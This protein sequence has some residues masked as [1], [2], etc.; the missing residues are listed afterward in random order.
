MN[1][2]DE[3]SVTEMERILDESS[4]AVMDALIRYC[5]AKEVEIEKE[6]NTTKA[7]VNND[8]EISIMKREVNVKKAEDL[9]KMKSKAL[10]LRQK[11]IL[12]EQFRRSQ[13][14]RKLKGRF[15]RPNRVNCRPPPHVRNIRQHSK[16]E[17]DPVEGLINRNIVHSCQ[18]C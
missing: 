18:L 4:S 9:K 13:G 1:F 6:Y 11:I 5:A 3:H 8:R 2:P 14:S 10:S 7:A 16:K 15:Y 12:P 17:C